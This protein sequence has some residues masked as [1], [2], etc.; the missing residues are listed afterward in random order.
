MTAR[1]IK[2]AEI[3]VWVVCSIGCVLLVCWEPML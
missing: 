1:I 2:A 3:T